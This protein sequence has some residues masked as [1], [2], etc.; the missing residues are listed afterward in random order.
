MH[1]L[2]NNMNHKYRYILAA[3]LSILFVAGY[4][5]SQSVVGGKTIAPMF[6]G[7]PAR[8]MANIIDKDIPIAWSVEEGKHKNVKWFAELGSITYS[9]PVVAD[10]KVFVGTNNAHPRD[11]KMKEKDKAV[12]MA[13]NEADGKFLWQLVHEMSEASSYRD[14]GLVST[15]MIEGKRIHYITPGCIVVCADT[16]GKIQWTYDMMKELKVYPHHC[17]GSS[18]LVVGDL[19][20]IVTGNGVNEEGKLMS[21]KAPSFIAFNKNTGKIVW[22]SNLP[23]ENII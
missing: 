1:R 9:G 4:S 14:F 2:R 22:Q 13:F 11:P 6:G 17:A 3:G 19:V 18:P 5:W 15:P 7:T 10:G 16:D 8:N 12:L 23:G 20:M 21:P